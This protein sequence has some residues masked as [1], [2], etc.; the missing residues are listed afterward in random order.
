[1]DRVADQSQV[2]VDMIILS[3]AHNCRKRPGK[4][5]RIESLENI[6]RH[7]LSFTCNRGACGEYGGTV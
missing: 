4:N 2:L 1:M 6:A 5:Q 7:S 3:A